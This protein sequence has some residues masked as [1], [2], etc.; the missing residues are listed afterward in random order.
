MEASSGRRRLGGIWRH[1]KA[2][3]G[4][5]RHLEASGGIWEAS[6]RHL[7]GIWEAS[8]RHL[9]GIWETFGRHL[10]GIWAKGGP[11]EDLKEI[12]PKH[13]CFSVESGATD[14]FACTRA[15]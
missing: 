15:T 8:G 4:I 3:G 11:E 13:M 14:R 6:E 10:G 1:L 5:W 7:G 2:S 9:G 12:V